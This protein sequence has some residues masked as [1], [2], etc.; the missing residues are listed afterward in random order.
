MGTTYLFDTRTQIVDE[1]KINSFQPE[2]KESSVEE[3]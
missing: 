3:T 1:G 2:I